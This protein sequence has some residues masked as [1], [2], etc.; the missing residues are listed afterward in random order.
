MESNTATTFSLL[1]RHLVDMYDDTDSRA[2]M[3]ELQ[4]IDYRPL[5]FARFTISA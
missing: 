5:G 4:I 3:R 1:V 2:L